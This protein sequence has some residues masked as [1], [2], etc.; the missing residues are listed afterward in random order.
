MASGPGAWV[1]P[2]GAK[3]RVFFRREPGAKLHS[4]AGFATWEAAEELAATA[5]TQITTRQRSVGDAIKMYQA[6]MDQRV[7]RNEMRPETASQNLQRLR[8][9]MAG[10]R[11]PAL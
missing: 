2:H 6:A 4:K 10:V 3:F 1:Y 5:L 11:D 9:L 7:A 8:R